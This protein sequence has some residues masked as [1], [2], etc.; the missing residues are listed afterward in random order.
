MRISHIALST[1]NLYGLKNERLVSDTRSIDGFAAIDGLSTERGATL[2][3]PSGT[4]LY[5]RPRYLETMKGVLPILAAPFTESGQIHY[6]SVRTQIAALADRGC[7]GAILFGFGT[8]FYK[9]TDEER[10][11]FVRVAV[12]AGGEHG[13]P[14]YASITDQSTVA[15]VDW[16]E[17][18]ADAGVDGL[19]VLPPHTGSPSED[20]L[21]EHLRRVGTATALPVMVQYA[22]QAVGG[23]IGPE[24]FARLSEEVP[25]I[26]DYK[27]ESQPPGPY[28]SALLEATDGEVNVLV[29]SA[30]Q[31]FIEAL[32]RGAV[33]VVPSGGM[34]ELYVHIYERYVAGDR[35]AAVE[36]HNALLPVLNQLVGSESFVHFDKWIQAER[37]FIADEAAHVRE[38]TSHPDEH[39]VSLF[40]EQY[41]RIESRLDD[42]DR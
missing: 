18:F 12:E 10:G 5:G 1:A 4:S 42:G 30:G 35:E 17:R 11:E 3:H 24:T 8:E 13:I 29:G 37:G 21:L 25:T 27:I 36:A 38:P 9:L 31:K 15:A 39:V 34:C 26:T 28:I 33:G 14:I 19:M 2:G 23:S 40:R 32:D 20:A 22:P 16:A 6:P 7:H 41:E